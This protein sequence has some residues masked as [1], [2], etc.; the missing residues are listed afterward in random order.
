MAGPIES[1]LSPATGGRGQT[2]S[3]E[4]RNESACQ[5]CGLWCTFDFACLVSVSHGSRIDAHSCGESVAATLT[6]NCTARCC[7]WPNSKWACSGERDN[8]TSSP[9]PST[10]SLHSTQP[11]R[12]SMAHS[13][14]TLP[15]HTRST[16]SGHGGPP[17]MGQRLNDLKQLREETIDLGGIRAG[18]CHSRGRPDGFTTA[19][20]TAH[21]QRCHRQ[22]PTPRRRFYRAGRISG[23]VCK[24]GTASHLAVPR[25]SC[26]NRCQR[27][28]VSLR[29]SG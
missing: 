20:T 21:A 18:V 2:L 19:S 29:H 25:P 24:R 7:T 6:P 22:H 27:T 11:L 12:L 1:S 28:V 14:M 3:G 5:C 26:V 8:P 4:L 23:R 10:A 9:T 17:S 15:Q 16:R 13:Q